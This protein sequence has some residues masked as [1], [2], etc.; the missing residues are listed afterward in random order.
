MLTQV[1][2]ARADIN[3]LIR[4]MGFAAAPLALT[5]GM[6]I[7]GLDYG[8]GLAALGLMFGSTLLAVQSATDAPAGKALIATAAGFAVWVIVVQLFAGST[9]T[10]APGIFIFAPR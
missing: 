10:Y 3:E 9:N 2:R 1:F 5:V 4:V 8:I 6:V 7:P